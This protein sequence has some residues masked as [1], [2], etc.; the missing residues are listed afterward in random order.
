MELLNTK[1]LL[2]TSARHLF[3]LNAVNHKAKEVN[4]RA[5]LAPWGSGAAV[6]RAELHLFQKGRLQYVTC[7]TTTPEHWV[8][9]IKMLNSSVSG[10]Y[11]RCTGPRL[12]LAERSSEGRSSE[13]RAR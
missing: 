5:E 6:S 9:A 1:Q 3:Y 12:P 4:L 11:T 2:L 7:V 8:E 10:S 13:R